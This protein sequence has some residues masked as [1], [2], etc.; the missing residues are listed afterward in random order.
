[1]SLKKSKSRLWVEGICAAF[2]AV[3]LLLTAEAAPAAPCDIRNNAPPFIQHDLT[4]S[5]CELCGYGYITILIS[6]PLDQIDLTDLVVIE[7]LRDSGLT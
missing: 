4:A 7:D 6:N 5:Y 2:S 1:M 3:L